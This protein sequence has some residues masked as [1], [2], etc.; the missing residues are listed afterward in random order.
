MTARVLASITMAIAVLAAGCGEDEP[1]AWAGFERIPA[2]L[3]S[4]QQLPAVEADGSETPFTFE[5]DDGEVLLVYFGYTSCPDV[6]PTTLADVRRVSDDIGDEAERLDLA[7]V[8]IDPEVDTPE[9][10][11]NYARSFLPDAIAIRTLDD[12]ALRTSADA[13]GADY[14][15][16]TPD[17]GEEQVYHTGSLYA[18]DDQGRLLLSWPFGIQREDLHRDLD[19]LLDETEGAQA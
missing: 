6:C 18:V 1:V 2:P 8:T 12:A 10:L 19:R 9:R 5:A 13:F 14:G 3:V 16:L 11:V 4:E 15:T 17:D 7:M